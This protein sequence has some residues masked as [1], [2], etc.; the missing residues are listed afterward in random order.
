MLSSELLKPD[1]NVH[2]KENSYTLNAGL[3]GTGVLMLAP[4]SSVL[5]AI[6]ITRHMYSI[7]LQVQ[8]LL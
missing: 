7:R 4:P 8:T 2:N 1:N 5:L 6:S 3:C